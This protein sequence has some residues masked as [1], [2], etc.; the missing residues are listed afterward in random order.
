MALGFDYSSSGPRLDDQA[1]EEL[2]GMAEQIVRSFLGEPNRRLSTR[3]ELR[4]GSKGSVK[5]VVEGDKQGLWKDYENDVGGVKE[6]RGCS[7]MFAPNRRC[8]E[9]KLPGVRVNR[10]EKHKMRGARLAEAP[11]SVVITRA[12][13]RTKTVTT[14][15]LKAQLIQTIKVNDI[16]VT[17]VDPFVE[18]YE[19]DENSNSEMKWAAIGWRDV[20]RAT[21]SAIWLIHHTKKYAAGMAGDMDASRGASALAGT[22]RVMSTIFPM[23]EDEA[24][25][26]G[27]PID[28][29]YKYIR[30]DDAKGSYALATKQARWFEKRTHTLANGDGIVPGDDVGVLV[31]WTPPGLMDDITHAQID[32]V[33]DILSRGVLNEDGSQSGVLYGFKKDNGF[34]AGKVLEDKF[35]C[36]SDRAKLILAAWEKSGSIERTIYK[37]PIQRKDREGLL[38]NAHKRPGSR[39]E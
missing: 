37:H 34:W 10:R 32:L 12:D 2:R 19:G 9:H 4:W 33:L 21:L 38:V 13:P 20:A 11:E 27:V 22:A 39:S 26:M 23:S 3:R 1:R 36:T 28:Q 17:I 25:L 15:P 31:P 35:G 29:R 14:T 30:F 18:T 8:E 7:I 5:L 16:D 6:Q 24:D